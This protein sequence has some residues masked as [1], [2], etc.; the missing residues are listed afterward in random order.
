MVLLICRGVGKSVRFSRS[1]GGFAMIEFC[2]LV[3]IVGA[4]LFV[5]GYVGGRITGR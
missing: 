1:K 4:V 5:T 3:G 2:G